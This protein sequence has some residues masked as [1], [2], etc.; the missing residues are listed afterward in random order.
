MN[1]RL[2]HILPSKQK[3]TATSSHYTFRTSGTSS[4][5]YI[6][7]QNDEVVIFQNRMLTAVRIMRLLFN[8]RIDSLATRQNTGSYKYLDLSNTPKH[9]QLQV[10]QSH[11]H[12]NTGS[13]KYP[14]LRNAKKLDQVLRRCKNS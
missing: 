2:S 4:Y 3:L 1:I 9:W 8:W 12:A 5:D 11:Q 14:I 6:L 13:N 10:P 7:K